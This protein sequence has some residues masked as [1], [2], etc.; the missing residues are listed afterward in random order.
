M[1]EA[2]ELTLKL[3]KLGLT[4]GTSRIGKWAAGSDAGRD[5]VPGAAEQRH[6]KLPRRKPRS[7][8]DRLV[9]ASEKARRIAKPA[10]STG[11]KFASK[12]CR[13]SS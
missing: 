10:N 11:A 4:E 13:A 5:Q 9:I 8:N 12:N 3:L 2:A 1:A 6:R 7:I